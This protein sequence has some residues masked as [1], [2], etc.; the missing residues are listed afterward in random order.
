MGEHSMAILK[1]TVGFV[2]I[3]S[4]SSLAYAQPTTPLLGRD[5]PSP[6]PSTTSKDVEETLNDSNEIKQA[7]FSAL[8]NADD[9]AA[10]FPELALR[11]G[12]AGSAKLRCVIDRGLLTDCFIIKETPPKLGFGEASLKAAKFFKLNKLDKTGMPVQGRN[13]ETNINWAMG[14]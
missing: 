6:T 7:S 4:V 10:L 12:I 13:F 1:I 9:L 14:H 8:P 2:V 3:L 5:Q 11:Q